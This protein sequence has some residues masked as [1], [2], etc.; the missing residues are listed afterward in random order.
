MSKRISITLSDDEYA[1]LVRLAEHCE[2]PVSTLAGEMLA[3]TVHATINLLNLVSQ[4]ADDPK[5]YARAHY[6][7]ASDPVGSA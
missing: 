4:I 6:L 5:Q 1:A 3:N 2:L 7:M